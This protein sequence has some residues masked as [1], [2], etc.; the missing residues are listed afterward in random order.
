MAHAY[1]SAQSSL[2]LGQIINSIPEKERGFPVSEE[3][4]HFPGEQYDPHLEKMKKLTLPPYSTHHAPDTTAH[5]KRRICFLTLK[6]VNL[7][8]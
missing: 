6:L 1:C 8:A 5:R 7:N 4:K 3:K 2:L